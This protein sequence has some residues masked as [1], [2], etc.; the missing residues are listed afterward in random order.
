M[1]KRGVFTIKAIP[2][3]NV[4]KGPPTKDRPSIKTTLRKRGTENTKV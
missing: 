4:R 2:I 3:K 1:K